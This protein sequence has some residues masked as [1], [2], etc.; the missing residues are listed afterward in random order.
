MLGL[1]RHSDQ[2]MTRPPADQREPPTLAPVIPLRRGL[3][4][5]AAATSVDEVYEA[6]HLYLYR[7]LIAVVHDPALAED[8]LQEAFLRLIRERSAGRSPDEPRAWLY[9]VA[10]NIAISG[11]RRARTATRS[12]PSLGDEDEARSPEDIAIDSERDTELRAALASIAPE[13]RAALILAAQ[14]FSSREIGA[15][16]G[17]SDAAV[18]TLLC[19][20][21]VRLRERLATPVG[22]LTVDELRLVPVGSEVM[23]ASLSD[24]RVVEAR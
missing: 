14:G 2:L 22:A 19:R 9:R 15:V 6:H 1:M 16:L 4:A 20:S 3:V 17:R 24:V 12:L 13:S 21:R 8:I 10:T 11:I 23:R 5:A 7:Y 18:R